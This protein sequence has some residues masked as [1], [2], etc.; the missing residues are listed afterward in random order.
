MAKGI[1]IGELSERYTEVEYL[2]SSGTQYIDTGY[3]PGGDTRIVCEFT[4]IT[5]GG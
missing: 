5:I 1:Y 2:Q 3:K 4:E